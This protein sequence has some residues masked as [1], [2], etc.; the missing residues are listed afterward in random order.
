MIIYKCKMCGGNLNISEGSKT[1]TCEYCQTQQTVPSADD[2]KRANLFNRANHFR[3]NSEFDKAMGIY[4]HILEE[5]SSDAEAYW[6]IVLCRYGIEYV[7]D[8]ATKIQKPTVNRT[9]AQSILRDAD[10]LMALEHADY[11]QKA[12]YEKEAQ[13]IDRIQSDILQI[14]QNEQPYDI[15]IS[16]KEKAPDGERTRSSVLAQ[17]VYNHLKKAG[18]KVFF[19]RISLEDK[20]GQKYEPYIYSALNSSKVM[21]VIGTQKDEF[22]A[23]WVRNEWSRFL[24]MMREDTGKLLIPCFRDLDIDDLPN[25]FQILQSQ[26]MS[27]IGFEQDLLHGIEKLLNVKDKKSEK[28]GEKGNN[29]LDR[30]LQNAATYMG[31][32]NYTAAYNTYQEITKL[33]PEDHRGWWGMMESDTGNFSD[34]RIS[35]EKRNILNKWFGYVRKLSDESSYMKKLETYLQYLQKI[36]H[37][38]AE[39]E[40]TS[41]KEMHKRLEADKGRLQAWYN[42]LPR[43]VDQERKTFTQAEEKLKAQ[44]GDARK[45][46]NKAS[47]R[48]T[49]KLVMYIIALVLAIGAAL[50]GVMLCF[51]ELPVSM[52]DEVLY[53]LMACPVIFIILFLIALKILG[54][55]GSMTEIKEEAAEAKNY[56]EQTE[57]ML[58]AN[59]KKFEERIQKV[60]DENSLCERN[61]E[62]CEQALSSC[63]QYMTLETDKVARLIY[64]M[65]CKEIGVDETV[66][67]DLYHLREKVKRSA[68]SDGIIK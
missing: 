48:A 5:D 21:L 28:T 66:D 14:A 46:Y 20:V 63:N 42:D 31:I 39:E 54:S 33:Y 65:D 51:G 52:P 50:T 22:M 3:Q 57:Q 4:E 41:V 32:E 35:T 10:Y 6:S 15:F 55:L 34:I 17:D 36:S 12:L 11:A 24:A 29:S 7:E 16:Y 61:I 18:Y 19:S 1:T 60:N 2:E 8:P 27:K 9:Q 40:M 38:Q 56:I 59:Q 53:F 58:Q 26:D 64:A 62:E 13:E 30:L 45:V 43:Q 37:M 67:E 25:E 44:I 49:F 23:P 47:A 68:L